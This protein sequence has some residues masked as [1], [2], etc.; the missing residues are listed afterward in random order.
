MSKTLAIALLWCCE[1]CCGS[2]YED[3]PGSC[4]NCQEYGT[5]VIERGIYRIAEL[6]DGC[7]WVAP[8]KAAL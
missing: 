3:C 4:D 1:V 2:D 6:D 8:H 5:I 7:R